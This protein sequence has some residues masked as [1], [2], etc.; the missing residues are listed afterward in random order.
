MRFWQSRVL[1]KKQA[2]QIT[3]RLSNKSRPIGPVNILL[4]DGLGFKEG[5][6]YTWDLRNALIYANWPAQILP[7]SFMKHE[8]G[9]WICGQ[10][11]NNP[12]TY[13]TLK[14]ALLSAKVDLQSDPERDAGIYTIM[15]GR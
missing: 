3:E 14:E 11:N 13:Q 6:Q 7:V 12:S 10:D 15:I 2:L 4:L 9:I 5:K 1:T 8:K